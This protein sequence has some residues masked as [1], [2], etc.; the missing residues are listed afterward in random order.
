MTNSQGFW[1]YVHDDDEAEG[2]RIHRLAR[3]IVAQ[4]EMLTGETISLFIDIDVL[5]WG[6]D[7]QNKIGLNLELVAFFIPVMTPRYFLSPQCRRELQFFARRA[8]KSGNKG[9]ILPLLYVDVPG[10]HDERPTDD[11]ITLVKTF[12]WVD[13]QSLRFSEVTSEVYRKGVYQ[14]VTGLVEANNEA[15]KIPAAFASNE[16]ETVDESVDDSPGSIDLLANSEEKLNKT[17]KTLSAIGQDI[18]IIGQMMHEAT[19]EIRQA[20]SQGKGFAG[21]LII[22]RRLTHHLTE[23]TNHIWSLS[24]EFASQ[25]HD[26]DEGFRVIIERAPAEIMDDT[27]SKDNFCTFI[28]S[29]RNLNDSSNVSLESIQEMI[30]A[31]EPLEK[32]SRDLRPVLRRLRQ[33]LTILV[34]S[35][36]VISEWVHLIESS[37]VDCGDTDSRTQKPA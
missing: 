24:N 29:V 33:G 3:D 10:I 16:S 22:A 4:Y 30:K 17:P 23:P 35:T 36:A 2:G 28:K 27:E 14:L 34:E 20:D 7:W 26:V 1:S 32:M 21:R 12:Q 9:L 18:G 6:D 5:R 13:W 11:L 37:G 25:L 8:T 15:E 19:G 31:I